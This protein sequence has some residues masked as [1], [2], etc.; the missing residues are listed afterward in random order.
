E[1]LAKDDANLPARTGLVLS[2]FDAG[3]R[4][5][6]E[7]ELTR[8]LEANPGNVIL[9]AGAAYWYAAHD[10]GEKAVELAQKAI[11]GDP[12]FIWSHIALARGYLSE[13]KPAIAERTLFAAR[14]YGNFPTLEYE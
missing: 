8:S 13:N 12:R 3:K 7:A 6:A 14:R 4:A 5:D 11:A 2:L 9:L 10:E 1:I